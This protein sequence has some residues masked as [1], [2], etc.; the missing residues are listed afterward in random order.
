MPEPLPLAEAL[1]SERFESDFE[2][3]PEPGFAR[4]EARNEEGNARTR[5]SSAGS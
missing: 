4:R 1:A 3:P 5:Q 2:R